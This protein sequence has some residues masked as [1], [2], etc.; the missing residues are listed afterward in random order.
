MGR[1]EGRGQAY[2]EKKGGPEAWAWPKDHVV[3]PQ[4]SASEV[5]EPSTQEPAFP[6]VMEFATPCVWYRDQQ[7]AESS[8]GSSPR[9]HHSSHHWGA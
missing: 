9:D 5:P 3:T 7:E 2:L 8:H 6:L 4:L 1:A